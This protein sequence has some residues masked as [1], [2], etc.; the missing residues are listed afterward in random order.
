METLV[1]GGCYFEIHHISWK[2][3]SYGVSQ[4]TFNNFQLCCTT[5]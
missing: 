3:A 5:E 2:K 4:K 1:S